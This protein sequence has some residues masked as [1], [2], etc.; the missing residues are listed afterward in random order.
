MCI[1]DRYWAIVMLASGVITDLLGAVST[2]L[3]YYTGGFFRDRKHGST[4]KTVQGK[5]EQQKTTK[6]NK[7]NQG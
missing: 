2:M 5:N 3:P 1:R 4:Q 6:T 7:R